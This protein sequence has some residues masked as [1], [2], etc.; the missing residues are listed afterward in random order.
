MRVL[1]VHERFG[2]LAGAEAN[3]Y[4][5]ATELK[6]RRHTVGIIHGRPTGKAETRWNDTF[7]DKFELKEDAVPSVQ[8]ALADF[9]PDIVYVHKMADLKVIETLLQSHARLV[10]MI[11]DHDIYCMRSYKYNYFTRS[12]CKRAASAHCVF[13][14]GAS[15]A[16][17]RG[18]ILP[19]KWVSY[20]D[21]KKEIALNQQFNR[22]VVVSRY[23]RNELLR[24]GFDVRKVEI[25]PPVPRAGDPSVRS[26]FSEKNLILYAGQII[27]GKG[28]D[29]LLRALALVKTPFEC[30]IL[31]EGTHKAY[32]EK[33]SVKLGLQ[34]RVKFMGFVPQEQLQDF[35]RECTVVAI[36]SVWPEPFATIG[37]EVM[38]YGLPV[39]AFDVGGISDWLIDGQN[40]YLV[41]AGDCTAYAGKLEALL[42]DKAVARKLGENGLKLVNEKFSFDSYIDD[43]EKMFGTV[44]SET[45]ANAVTSSAYQLCPS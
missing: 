22:L 5:T 40:G 3:L 33:L 30:I 9:K 36:S 43:L 18:G 37:M 38:R 44:I 24:N 42:R 10:R 32:C 26:N 4:L 17:N 19:I 14:C 15:I 23:M 8:R 41:P 27:R 11:H 2:A 29:V 7:A 39:V 16:R 35:Y 25:H 34:D 28:V 13:P 31:G 20:F 21:K 45:G 12:V 6:R 1:F